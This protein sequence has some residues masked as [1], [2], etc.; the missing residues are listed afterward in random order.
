VDV[1]PVDG[2]RELRQG[3][4]S[5]LDPAQVVVAGPVAG[6]FLQ[7][8]QLHALGA[9]GDQLPGRPTGRRDTPPQVLQRPIRNAD[10]KGADRCGPREVIARD[11][12]VGLL[13]W[14]GL[15]VDVELAVLDGAGDF[16]T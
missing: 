2:G 15:V 12:H 3:V 9:V 6:Q 10:L 11:R 4:Q 7:G 14:C 13:G 16:L 5:G 1:D 8:G